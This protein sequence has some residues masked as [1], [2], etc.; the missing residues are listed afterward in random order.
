MNY[1][2]CIDVLNILITT[3]YGTIVFKI[4]KPNYVPI[5]PIIY[6]I[7]TVINYYRDSMT[8]AIILQTKRN[9]YN[10]F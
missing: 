5:Y 8:Y 4:I 10:Y 3:Y 7:N 9:K 2:T 6:F 1:K